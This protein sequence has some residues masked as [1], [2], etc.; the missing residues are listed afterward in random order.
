MGFVVVVCDVTHIIIT[1]V[2]FRKT[3]QRVN[4][5]FCFKICLDD[6]K[7]ARATADG[8]RY[9][10]ALFYSV[11]ARQAERVLTLQHLRISEEMEANRTFRILFEIVFH[12]SIVNK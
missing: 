8:A 9:V 10:V 6:V 5:L 1:F 12:F 7:R 2:V 11:N 4:Q 3:L